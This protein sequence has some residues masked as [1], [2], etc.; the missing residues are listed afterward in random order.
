MMGHHFDVLYSY[1]KAK[2]LKRKKLEHKYNLGIKDSLLSQML[3]SLSWD[4]KVPAKAQSLWQYAFGET[5]DGTS[6]NSMTGKEMQNQIWRRLLNNLPYLL[7]HKGSSRAVKAALACYGVPSSMLTM[8]F[9]GPRNADGGT[10]KFSFEDRTDA[11]NISGSQQVLIPWKEY[12]D[13][14]DYPNCIEVRINSDKRQN[15]SVISS[16]LWSVDVLHFQ[17][18]QGKLKLS[19]ADNTSVYSVTSSSIL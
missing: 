5:S 18:N 6:V 14:S 2:Y 11:L 7:K 12:T 13:T 9:G 8:E 17:G 10:N 3:K 1:T 15:Q 19:V 16:S 4:S